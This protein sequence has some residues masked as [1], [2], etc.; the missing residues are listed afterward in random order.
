[1]D[2]SDTSELD[3]PAYKIEYICKA[4]GREEKSCIRNKESPSAFRKAIDTSC[5]VSVAGYEDAKRSV[6]NN[7]SVADIK[8]DTD[9]LI[10]LQD[11]TQEPGDHCG[12]APCNKAVEHIVLMGKDISCKVY[13][14]K[15][16]L[17]RSYLIG[18]SLALTCKIVEK[19]SVYS[20]KKCCSDKD[21]YSEDTC[22][23]YAVLAEDEDTSND[24]CGPCQRKKPSP[25]SNIYTRSNC[26][27]AYCG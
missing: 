12:K 8:E 21:V 24:T 4:C 26:R 25:A 15:A 13:P 27:A 2:R 3:V 5:Q 10:A 6:D 9:E 20:C 22:H 19:I 18:M 1:M 7:K 11:R 16:I 23:K 14:Y 17:M